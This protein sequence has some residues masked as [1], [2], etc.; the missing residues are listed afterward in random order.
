[1]TEASL[2]RLGLP[3]NDF[4]VTLMSLRLPPAALRKRSKWAAVLRVITRTS[5][6]EGLGASSLTASPSPGLGFAQI[7]SGPR[8]VSASSVPDGDSPHVFQTVPDT[9]AAHFWALCMLRL[10]G[11]LMSSA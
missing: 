6:G 1:M 9:T 11:P 10:R 5:S 7:I 2:R 8:S 4:R 3:E